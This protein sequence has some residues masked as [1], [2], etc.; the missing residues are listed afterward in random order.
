MPFGIFLEDLGKKNQMPTLIRGCTNRGICHGVLG[1][2]DPKK[3]KTGIIFISGKK[4]D[5]CYR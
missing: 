5:W 2:L 1:L 3:P 4:K